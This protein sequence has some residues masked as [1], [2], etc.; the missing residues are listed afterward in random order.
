MYAIIIK[1]D[2]R[3]CDYEEYAVIGRKC[4][5]EPGALQAYFLANDFSAAVSGYDSTYAS[6]RD[7]CFYD[8]L[9]KHFSRGWNTQMALLA[10]KGSLLNFSSNH[11][12]RCLE[13][14]EA[15]LVAGTVMEILDDED[16]CKSIMEATLISMEE[17]IMEEIQCYA[18]ERDK[19]IEELTEAE[20]DAALDCFSD[21]F[22]GKMMNLLEQVQQ[23]PAILKI[24]KSMPAHEDFDEKAWNNYDKIDFERKWNH[25]RTQTGAI[26]ELDEEMERTAQDPRAQ[27]P[28][29]AINNGLNAAFTG[30]EISLQLL[31]AFI[32]SVKDSTDREILYLRADGLTLQEI[33]QRLG[34]KNHSAV[35]KRMDKLRKR[36]K[37]FIS[38]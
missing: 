6:S 3:G 8:R 31:N 19:P 22:L 30:E 23:V 13:E 1:I 21:R 20:M 10:N 4:R 28:F 37:A 16:L 2:G 29:F 38:E 33:A 17:P 15:R 32:Q 5:S 36:F 18:Q 11:P 34:F 12:V 24:G 35:V 7:N 9:Q 27:M 14:A 26:L 25:L